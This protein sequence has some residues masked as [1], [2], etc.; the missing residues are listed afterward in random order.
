MWDF[1]R[2]P[3]KTNIAFQGGCTTKSGYLC[4]PARPDSFCPVGQIE[5]SDWSVQFVRLDDSAAPP[6][7]GANAGEQVAYSSAFPPDFE[8]RRRKPLFHIVF[9][10][11]TKTDPTGNDRPSRRA[12]RVRRRRQALVFDPQDAPGTPGSHIAGLVPP[13][14][15]VRIPMNPSL[16]YLTYILDGWAHHAL[17]HTS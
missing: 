9:R 10:H 1:V 8:V 2:K 4:G 15:P 5:L 7:H 17:F 12:G 6:A 16:P 11:V 13:V 3:R 14:C